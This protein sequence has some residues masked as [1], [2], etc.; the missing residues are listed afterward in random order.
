MNANIVDACVHNT[1]KNRLIDNYTKTTT[2]TIDVYKV[3]D[4]QIKFVREIKR[5]SL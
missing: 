1:T 2:K 4:T 5:C 3:T